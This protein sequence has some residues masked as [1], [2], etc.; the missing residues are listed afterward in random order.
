M[1]LTGAEL[2]VHLLEQQGIRLV[3]GIPGGA[4]LPLY[5]A[6][7]RSS[8][9]RHVLARHEQAAGFIAQGMARITGKAGVCL[10]TS[11]PGAT[12][13]VT[14]LADAKLDSVPMVC[15]TGQVPQHLIGTDAFQ[16]VPTLD[17]VKPITKAAFL[18][19]SASELWR[20]LPEAFRL[21]ESGRPGPVLVDVPKDVQSQKIEGVCPTGHPLPAADTTTAHVAQ[22][23]QPTSSRRSRRSRLAL[24]QQ[25]ASTEI[26]E[27][28]GRPMF[29]EQRTLDGN[30]SAYDE[31]IEL[32]RDSRRPVLYV[33]GGIVK[34]RAHHLVREL[35]ELAGIPV[36]TTLMGLG[37]LPTNHPLGLGMLGMHGARY[38]NRVLDECDLLIAIGARFDDRATGRPE[39]FAAG[40]K[41]IHIDIDAREFGKI[42]QPTLAIRDDAH[43]A[44]G[45]LI[46]RTH[47]QHRSEWL[48]RVCELRA[49]FPLQ[50][51]GADRICSPYG[52][53]HAV[54][55]LASDDVI[56]TTDVGQHQM[57]VAQ[58]YPFRRPD[59]WLTSGG[60]GTMGFGLPAAIGAALAKPG[61]S[62]VCFTGDG[63]LLMNIQEF[64]TLAELDLNVK[65][66]V[67]DNA[68]LGMV[69]QQQELFY[70]KRFV[71]SQ[72]QAPSDFVAIAQAFGIAALD[73]ESSSAPYGALAKALNSEGPMLIRV[74]IAEEQHVL[75]MVAP[76]DANVDALDY[77]PLTAA[78]AC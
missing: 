19:R 62:V 55:Q 8:R 47:H 4:L 48:R 31:A 38:T 60:L 72:F 22:D 67:L 18:V 34:A 51:P 15:I 1:T 37:T 69:R 73:L 68:S 28:S 75:P 71:A 45:E 54:G 6:L 21:A 70:G 56:I 40:A 49:E 26:H 29:M 59:R 57:W 77:P 74:P 65:I 30:G 61:A 17:I 42:R 23:S 52:I 11:G 58:A 3:A 66:I 9:I 50:T 53:V 46:A 20:V 14:A 24:Q 33:G 12:N 5:A 78:T 44:L 36:T 13:I 16:E 27:A 35:A 2:I 32:I 64:A 63:S 25:N 7:G 39:R 43:C 76:G 10:A 41:V